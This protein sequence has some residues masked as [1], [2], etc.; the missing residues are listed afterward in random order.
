MVWALNVALNKPDKAALKAVWVRVNT[1]VAISARKASVRN[2]R[3]TRV[4]ICVSS[5]RVLCSVLPLGNPDQSEQAAAEEVE[6]RGLATRM[7]SQAMPNFGGQI[8]ISVH[9]SRPLSK[10]C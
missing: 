7:I 4:N 9:Y 2:S 1:L 8:S 5:S 10:A 6:S 3:F